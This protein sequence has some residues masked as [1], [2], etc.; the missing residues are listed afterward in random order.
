[1]MR[2]SSFADNLRRDLEEAL[3]LLKDY[4]PD[5]TPKARLIEPLPSLLEQC[6][7]LCARIPEAEPIRTIHHMACTGGTLISKCLAVMP[8]VALLSEIDPLSRITLSEDGHRKFAP[9]EVIYAARTALRPIDDAA[10]ER[11]FAA[12]V[13]ALHRVLCERGQRLVM[14]DH[15]HSQFCTQV[16][17][18]QRPTVREMLAKDH[19]ILSVV[20]VRHPL[21][22]FLSL[23]R[24]QWTH[25][26][27]YTI[28]EY[29]RRYRAFLDR[30]DGLRIFR[31]EDFITD[32]DGVLREMCMELALRF[33]AGAEDLFG[34]VAL[35]GDSGRTGKRIGKRSRHE[36]PE[37]I[38]RQ[39]ARS[40]AYVRLCDSSGLQSG[41]GLNSLDCCLSTS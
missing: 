3:Y 5:Q 35:S 13:E 26:T 32:P 21:D 9:T 39:A 33:A 14:R 12:S 7:A 4:I 27:P 10:T 24:N 37:E 29:A 6:Q 2:P 8:N 18:E 15:V 25:F 17:F 38:Q 31:Y 41:H 34:V 30:H 20:T 19:R 23:R 40:R 16:D 11:V 1:M 22:S 28:E 36:V